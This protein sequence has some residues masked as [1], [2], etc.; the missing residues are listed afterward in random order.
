MRKSTQW[1]ALTVLPCLLAACGN[2]AGGGNGGADSGPKC[3]TAKVANS[4]S[5]LLPGQIARGAVGDLII[6]NGRLKAVI[7]KG[8]RNWYNISQFGGN[9]IDALPK[10]ANG[11]VVGKD[12]FEELVL[13]TNIE[14]APNYQTV[15]VVNPGG[16]KSDGSCE[17]AV[18]RASGIGGSGAEDDLI[19]FIN[20]STAI[21]GLSLS[22]IPLNFPTSA[23]DR[24]LP[25]RFI[26]DYTLDADLGYIRMDTR[27]INPT[28]AAERLYLAEYI[29][30]SGEVEVFQH[31]YGFGE[32]FAA[33]PCTRCNYIAFAGH[34]GGA[35]VSYG[36]IHTQAST[37]SVSVS[38]V[39]VILYGRDIVQVALTPEPLQ[40]ATPTAAPNFT[41]PANGELTFTR[42]F[43]VGDGTVSS[44]VDL[45][46][47]IH[48]LATGTVE[49]LVTDASGPVANAEIAMISS[50][51]DGFAVGRGP[52]TTVVNH[53]RTDR[54]GRYRGTY[55]PGNYTLMV[56]APNR[57][58]PTPATASITIAANTTVTQNFSAPVASAIRVQ[59]K[60]STGRSLPA[61]VQL[62]GARLGPD[63][64]EPLNQDQLI[65]GNQLGIFTGFYGDAGADPLPPGVAL[66][67]FAVRDDGSGP[68][69]VG[70]TGVL[71]IEPGTYQLS[72]SHGPRYSHSL[73]SITVPA[74]GTLEVNAVLT[75]VMPTP[76]HIYGDFHVHSI[77]SPDSEVTNRERV[78]TYLAEGMDFFTPSDHDHRVDFSP[79]IRDMGVTSLIATAPSAEITTFD[80]GHYNVWP[81]AIETNSPNDELMNEGHST[82]PKISRGSTDWGGQ[83]PYG[84]DFPSQGNFNLTPQ[85][86]FDSAELDPQQS[87]RTVVKQINHIDWHFGT[88]NGGLSINTG[89]NPPQSTTPAAARRLN[90][91]VG[92]FYSDDYDT[93]ELL[94]GTDG[95]EYDDI[96][97]DQ[98]LGDWF[99][100]LN[101]GRFHTAMANSDT[102]QR[103]ITSLHT[104][105]QISVPASLLTSGRAN[106]TAIT[107]DAHTVGDHVRAGRNTITNA[108]FLV[109]KAA[110]TSGQGAGLEV[111]DPFGGITNPLP[112][113]G[114][115]T[116]QID[117]QSPLWAPYDQILVF[118]N[119]HTVRSQPANPPRYELCGPP[120]AQKLDLGTAGFSRTTP[121]GIARFETTKTLTLPNP[122][123]DYWI[124][125]MVRGTRGVSPTM[126]PVVPNS[127]ED[128]A[129][130]ISGNSD[131][132]GIRALAMSN[133]IY[134]D[135]NGGGWTAPGISTTTHTGATLPPDACPTGAMPVP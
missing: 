6:E 67:E 50:G 124:V 31:G 107:A 109:V 79:V 129:D 82:D 127:Y 83:A 11:N 73:Q 59:V 125:V 68:A 135:V 80:Y 110:N 116:L 106:M 23:D 65:A 53:F 91:A 100:L 46:N 101:Q 28:S 128:G 113:S 87:G 104:R 114:N 35:G 5:D 9:I 29:N 60:D 88:G 21:R 16:R 118:V 32:A 64:G 43:A 1:L 51:R 96:F 55:P 40:A 112:A 37:S 47:Q 97:Y 103:R 15:T 108:P 42:Y 119:G 3:A 2:G 115:V 10:N 105:N 20:G 56:N 54:N 134:V 92:N 36:L 74:S 49:G 71:P 78:A 14:S 45:R 63:G 98:N 84:K 34:D 126:W 130:N 111:T 94:I 7:Q 44:I 99:N 132:V 12:N 122:G 30:G 57:L 62:L 4:P 52:T 13:G 48:G 85:Q 81:V 72:V 121:A 66:S 120:A 90:P 38:G 19:D 25:L 27:M 26:T 70:D 102:H 89:V 18:I 133:P 131:D 61:K 75:E 93:L 24:D 8:G 39:S 117:V 17:P 41:V 58:A 95:L 76:N 77:N 69:F 22:G 86:I 33:A 123:R